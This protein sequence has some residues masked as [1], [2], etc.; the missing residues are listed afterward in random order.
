M[1]NPKKTLPDLP[2]RLNV[3]CAALMQFILLSA[4]YTACFIR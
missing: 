3:S 4:Y 1:F 2:D